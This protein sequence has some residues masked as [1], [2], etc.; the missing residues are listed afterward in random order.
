MKKLKFFTC[1][2]LLSAFIQQCAVNPVTGKKELMLLSKDQEVAMGSEA[3]PE[4]VAAYGLYP[5]RELQQ[6]ITS[7]GQKMVEVS[8]R[9]G[10]KYE[11]KIL[12]SP[13]VNA[14]AVPGGYVY[15]T[16][17]ILAHLNSEAEFA[18]VL[19][20]EIGHITARHS[21]KQYSRAMVAQLGLALGSIVSEEFAQF[22]DIASTGAGL[23]FLKYGRDAERESDR[24]GVEYS[25]K[26]GYDAREMAN[27]FR[28]LKS[29]DTS[30]ESLPVFLSTHPDPGEREKNVT[31]LANKWQRKT[32]LANYQI[33]RNT[34]L[35]KIDGL[36]Y[37]D[38]PRQGYVD[39][40]TFYHPELKFSFPIPNGWALENTP[41][42]VN[43]IAP[44]KD[45][46]IVLGL[47]G[48]KDLDN[49]ARTL[50]D[51]YGLQ[52]VAA[53]RTRIRDFDAINLHATQ[54]SQNQALRLSVFLISYDG[55]IYEFISATTPQQFSVL[56]PVAE[57]V[58]TGFNVLTDQSRLNVQ[59]R[60]I[61]IRGANSTTTLSRALS[62]EGVPEEKL[63]EH[64]SLNGMELNEN[65][66][67]GTLFKILIGRDFSGVTVKR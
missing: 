56:V 63:Q 35:R 33:N 10:I 66:E 60:R 59:P 41:Q 28:T 15:F 1:L 2:L 64:A 67:Q 55:R 11:F 9:P 61:A 48:E 51:R 17:G 62:S 50:V 49:A 57:R 45:A 39:N 7:E 37:G 23:L 46:I 25:T 54:A 31:E 58:A 26:T 21:A 20:H 43:M 53:Q 42:Q 8:H 32:D 65:I 13:I 38:D 47:S 14:F 5:S 18:G 44:S 6:F 24:L 19:G 12:D 29:M 34:Y 22:S 52:D 27:F 3:D 16:R 36:I 4:I 30:G 40:N